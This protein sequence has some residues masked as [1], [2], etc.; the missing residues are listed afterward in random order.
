M[1]RCDGEPLTRQQKRAH[2]AA[3]ADLEWPARMALRTRFAEAQNWRCCYCSTRMDGRG[4]EDNAPTLEHILPSGILHI[5]DADNC[6]VACRLC[7]V[8]RGTQIW[9][10]HIEALAEI[11]GFAKSDIARFLGAANNDE[12]A[13]RIAV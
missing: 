1:L 12:D 10:I 8:K 3:V 13:D 9:P 7:N 4:T 11:T 5:D 6:A 2:R